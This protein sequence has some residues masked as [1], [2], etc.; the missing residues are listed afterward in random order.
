MLEAA[1]RVK[2]LFAVAAFNPWGGQPGLLVKTES[3][4]SAI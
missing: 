4:G 1:R 3:L 2:P